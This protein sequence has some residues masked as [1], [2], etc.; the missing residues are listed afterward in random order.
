MGK[1]AVGPLCANTTVGRPFAG[2]AGEA[3]VAGR[4]LDGVH[5]RPPGASKVRGPPA[6]Q[7]R[8]SSAGPRRWS[9]RWCPPSA[10]SKHTA[11]NPVSVRRTTARRGGPRCSRAAV[12]TRCAGRGQRWV[13]PDGGQ[14]GGQRHGMRAVQDREPP[15][16]KRRAPASGQSLPSAPANSAS[17]G[18]TLTRIAA[19]EGHPV[20]VPPAGPVAD[21]ESGD[22]RRSTPPAR[23]TRP[24]HPG[25]G[26]PLRQSAVRAELRGPGT[27]LVPQHRRVVPADPGH[28]PAL[29]R[30]AARSRSPARTPASARRPGSSAALPSS[31]TAAGHV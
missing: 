3:G 24:G 23:R 11:V 21:R 20:D 10:V 22:R 16:G 30:S 19:I 26:G 2:Q 13:S 29:A 8:R 1:R 14:D 12:T 28:V 15:A 25:P 17:R 18:H 4:R 7:V 31:G 27:A 6:R 9:R 5:R